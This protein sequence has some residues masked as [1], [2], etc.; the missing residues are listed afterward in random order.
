MPD[1]NPDILRWARETAG[2]SLEEAGA[3]VGI[4]PARGK[5]S[6]ERLDQIERGQR[7]PSRPLLLKLA[8][9]YRRSLLIFY[10]QTPPAKGDRGRDFRTLPDSPAPQL[11]AWVDALIRD[12]KG[13]QA[14]VRTL[15]E[16]EEAPLRSFV[17]SATTKLDARNLAS[18]IADEIDF[19]L[20]D[21]RRER[22]IGGAISYL[23]QK[24]ENAGIFVILV[25]NLGNHHTAIPVEVFRGFAIAD[26]IAPFIVVNDRDAKPAW[27][28]TIFHELAHL[29]LGQT[30]ISGER[31]GSSTEQYCNDVQSHNGVV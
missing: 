5:T 18:R 10:L 16:E 13:R 19:A 20:P 29:W 2:L 15:L 14:L 21:Y 31:A 4:G 17:G 6:A 3:A 30:G 25:G 8:K 26:P 23:R 9:A 22:D 12:I 24:V 7:S 27:A 11:N 28:F 1:V